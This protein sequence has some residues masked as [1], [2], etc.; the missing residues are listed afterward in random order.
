MSHPWCGQ[1]PK[2]TPHSRSARFSRNTSFDQSRATSPVRSHAATVSKIVQ[3]CAR[4]AIIAVPD[5]EKQ[6][7]STPSPRK[8]WFL[9]HSCIAITANS[10]ADP[11]CSL[12][13][14]ASA[15]DPRKVS[16]HCGYFE[17]RLSGDLLRLALGSGGHM[18]WKAGDGIGVRIRRKSACRFSDEL[19]LRKIAQRWLPATKAPKRV[20]ITGNFGERIWT[21]IE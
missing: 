7:A 21:R 2:G 8:S 18:R 1:N 4:P 10:F 20:L 15:S 11:G 19:S 6:P 9:D 5:S 13:I 14:T 12:D 16:L 3:H 17:V